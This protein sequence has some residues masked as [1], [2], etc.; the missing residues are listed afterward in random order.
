MIQKWCAD[1][2]LY[3][4]PRAGDCPFCDLPEHLKDCQ[5]EHCVRER[6]YEAEAVRARS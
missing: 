1:C 4:D 5:C 3:Y 2:K 6:A